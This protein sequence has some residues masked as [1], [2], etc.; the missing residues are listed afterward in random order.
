MTFDLLTT[1]VVLGT[2]YI[3]ICKEPYRRWRRKNTLLTLEFA[4]RR[5]RGVVVVVLRRRYHSF[6]AWNLFFLPNIAF[7][8][9]P[10]VGRYHHKS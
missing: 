5:R 2:C 8:L 6:L 1:E 9:L 4:A 7:L 3:I 10:M